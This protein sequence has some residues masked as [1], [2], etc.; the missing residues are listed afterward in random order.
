MCPNSGG[1]LLKL[2][3]TDNVDLNVDQSSKIK[4]LVVFVDN[5]A[6]LDIARKGTTS[7]KTKHIGIRAARAHEIME[8]EHIE[9][10][11]KNTKAMLADIFTKPVSV[12]VMKTL[13]PQLLVDE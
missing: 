8:K 3:Y 7:G 12:E 5:T 2:A 13:L 11:Y 1:A 6:A 9:Y 4:P 10:I